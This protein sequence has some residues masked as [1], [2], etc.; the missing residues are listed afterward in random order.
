MNKLK[1]V[2]CSV[3]LLQCVL[4][5][6]G[7]FSLT[8]KAAQSKEYKVDISRIVARLDAGEKLQNI[9]LQD[10]PNISDVQLFHPEEKS[11]SEYEVEEAAGQLYRFEYQHQEKNDTLIWFDVLMIGMMGMTWFVFV[12]VDVKI[13]RPFQNMKNLTL[14]LA[15]GNLAQPV[16]QEKSKYFK[17]FLWGT[18]MLREKLESDKKRE[19]AL[20]KEKKM[21]ILSLSHDI[22]TPL[23]AIDLYAKALSLDLYQSK[24]KREEIVTG[25]NKNVSEIKSYVNQITEA[26][27]EDFLSL[28]VSNEEVYFSDIIT[29]IET[30][31]QEKCR[32]LQITF[33]VNPVENCMVYGDRDRIVEV[34]QNLVENA[35]KY[36]DGKEIAISFDEEEDC[37]LITVA[38]TGCTLKEDELLHLFDS[39][40]RGSNSE[41]VDGSGLGLYI[42][43]ELMHKM[44]GDV[45]VKMD[46][47]RFLA[48]VVLKKC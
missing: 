21:L 43:K 6:I 10:Y 36:G 35:I 5:L 33:W 15:K 24:E 26:Q 41:R 45:F 30:Y 20:V 12:Y 18:D 38:N 8:G 46:G 19:L 28:E 32:Q 23:A 47:D 2:A 48:T 17:D 1:K 27:R 40:Y 44:D 42:C 3:I 11:K 39:F 7:N 16:R 31:Y 4:L 13:L 9:D 34:L 37:R 22:K 25:I 29:Q 14:E